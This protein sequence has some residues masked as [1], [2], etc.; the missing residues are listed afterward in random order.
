MAT[1]NVRLRAYDTRYARAV[2]GVNWGVITNNRFYYKTLETTNN[3]SK[4]Y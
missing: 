2:S 1:T 4:V 3:R